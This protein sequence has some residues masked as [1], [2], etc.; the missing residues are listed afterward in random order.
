MIENDIEVIEAKKIEKNMFVWVFCF[1]LGAFG[2]DR[3]MR[4]K[5]G[6]GVVKLLFGWFTF[7][8]WWFVDWLIALIKAYGSAYGQDSEIAFDSHGRYIR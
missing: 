6:S 5:I 4:G 7:G 2:V 3:F 8:I 1:L